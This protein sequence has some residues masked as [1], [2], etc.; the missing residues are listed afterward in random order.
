[1]PPAGDSSNCSGARTSASA[2]NVTVIRAPK[3]SRRTSRGS[4]SPAQ[5]NR[6]QLPPSPR[7][8]SRSASRG[9]G[10]YRG[11]WQPPPAVTP[12]TNTRHRNIRPRRLGAM[13]SPESA[14]EI[15]SVATRWTDRS[16]TST[17]ICPPA[18]VASAALSSRFP[19]MVTRSA[20]RISAEGPF[21]QHRQSR[22]LFNTDVDPEFLGAGLLHEEQGR[23]F[24]LSDPGSALPRPPGCL[25]FS[26]G[27]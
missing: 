9:S 21:R 1:M 25:R 20:R 8:G 7:A 3:C 12:L 24:K 2:G 13:P 22:V 19:M 4:G 26:H 27:K 18:P 23:D 5:G 14:T 17:E 10:Q 11:P 15:T 6:R 16:L